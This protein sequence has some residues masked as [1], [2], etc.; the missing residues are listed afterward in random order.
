MLT[1]SLNVFLKALVLTC[2]L[3]YCLTWP[4]LV[5][6]SLLSWSAF[7]KKF[8]VLNNHN[9]FH[10]SYFAEICII[11]VKVVFCLISCS[12]NLRLT[13]FIRCYVILWICTL[14]CFNTSETQCFIRLR[15]RLSSN[16]KMFDNIS[17]LIRCFMFYAWK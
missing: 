8:I 5:H 15:H 17:T 2:K 1:D 11:K 10:E 16:W 14:D 4:L 7:R 13:N 3:H 6:A 9:T 12:I